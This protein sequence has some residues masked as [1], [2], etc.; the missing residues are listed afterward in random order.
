MKMNLVSKI[1]VGCAVLVI[2][3]GASSH[4]K[5]DGLVLVTPDIQKLVPPL[6]AL[7][8]QHRG[9]STTERGGVRWDGSGDQWFG[10]T[11]AGPHQHTVSLT[12]I[13]I[14]RAS[15]LGVLLNINEQGNARNTPITVDMLLLTAYDQNGR[16]VWSADLM[17]GQSV[18]LD[19]FRHGI[20][21]N[22]DYFLFGLDSEAA[23]RLQAAMDADP[24]LRL[25]LEAALSN[26]DGGPERFQF[27]A[28][29]Q[30]VP[31]PA[32]MV[33][34]GTGI[35]GVAA[36]ARKRRRKEAAKSEINAS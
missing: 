1:V 25:G 15:D 17:N 5:A 34:L 13:G 10:D 30:P 18:S 36:A 8:L 21:A 26:V 20:G 3:A 28:R 27:G 22:S 16:A 24:N 33:L 12:D 14:R 9:N 2:I 11:S 23:A 19:Q 31:E 29:T 32:T 7:N 6:A 35:A 4:A